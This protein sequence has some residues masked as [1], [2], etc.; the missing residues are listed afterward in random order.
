MLQNR[1][2]KLG[3]NLADAWNNKGEA[4][5]AL[6]RTAE[7]NAAFAKAEELGIRLIPTP[8]FKYDNL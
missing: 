2:I 7:A 4:F 8:S 6:G 3:P 5:K 1:A